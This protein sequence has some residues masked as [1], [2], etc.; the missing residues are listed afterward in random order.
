MYPRINR[1]RSGLDACSTA[2]SRCR[3]VLYIPLR[4]SQESFRYY[5]P[6]S[7]LRYWGFSLLLTRK[8]NRSRTDC[9]RSARCVSRRSSCALLEYC[10][11]RPPP[12][13][14]IWRPHFPEP[15]N[16]TNGPSSP[17]RQHRW[18]PAQL[19]EDR[20]ARRRAHA[21]A[22][23]S[24]SRCSSTP[25]STT[26]RSMSRGLLRRARHPAARRQPRRR[27]RQPRGADRGD[28]ARRSSRCCSAAPAGPRARGRR[29]E[30][31]DRLRARR[32]RSSACRSAHV[33][34]G[35]RSFDRDMPEEIN[36]VLTD[37][38]SDLLFTTEASGVENLRREGVDRRQG[39]LRRQRDDR[40][41]A[42]P[43]AS[44]RAPRA[45]HG[46]ARARARRLRRAD[47]A[48]AEQR[49]RRGGVRA[50]DAGHRR[51]GRRGSPIVFPVHPRTRPAVARFADCVGAHRRRGSRCASSS[52]SA[53]ST[54]SG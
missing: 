5:M 48:P 52:R 1:V 2:S 9:S 18:R 38:I 6:V 28:H 20:A 8:V 33:E 51:G 23:R 42:A 26:T 29:R 27:L 7:L 25:G 53:T 46:D 50:A 31:H 39:P 32:G 54:S 35:L 34:A 45:I 16:P 41:A 22:G 13:E 40:H 43:T 12:W 4:L 30:L 3:R 49:R 24:S 11:D 17:H 21:A 36:R 47:A 14:R 44:A 19:H 15:I 10:F 37:A